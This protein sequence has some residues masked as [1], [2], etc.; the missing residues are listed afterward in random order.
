MGLSTGKVLDNTTKNK[1]CCSCDEA[2][3][4]NNQKTMSEKK[5]SRVFKINLAFSCS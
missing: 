4:E 2:R 5:S 3:Q 1:M